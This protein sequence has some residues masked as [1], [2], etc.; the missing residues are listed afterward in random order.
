MLEIQANKLKSDDGDTLDQF[1]KDAAFVKNNN[2][3]KERGY[4]LDDDAIVANCELFIVGG[5]DTTQSLLLYAAYNLAL[6]PEIQEK[7]RKEVDET[8]KN[9]DGE[10]SYDA[11]NKMEYMD[12][13]L[14]GKLNINN[15]N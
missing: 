6:N 12:M 3:A 8:F 15:N 14:N 7:L 5:F 1:E 9:G 4:E 11:N 2:K 13:V 10:L